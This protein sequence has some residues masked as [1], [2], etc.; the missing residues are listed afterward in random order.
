MINCLPI[1]RGINVNRGQVSCL[2]LIIVIAITTLAVPSTYAITVN[3]TNFSTALDTN[4]KSWLDGSTFKYQV[5]PIVSTAS[6]GNGILANTVFELRN[7]YHLN[8]L[9]TAGYTGK[10][11]TIVIVNAY[12]SPTICEDLL[13]FIQWQNANGA[14]L[15]WTKIE[16]IKNHLRI[17]YPMGRPIF[18]A[19]DPNQLAWSTET[20]LDVDMVHGIAPD[21]DIALVIAPNN[22]NRPLDYAV[23]YSIFNHLG[24]TISLSWGEPESEII[25]QN[26]VSQVRISHAIFKLA[27]YEG[28]TVFAGS[29]D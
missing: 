23:F 25:E 3:V 10:G 18:D 21:A 4:Y 28:I 29:G 11:Q 17:Y 16:E 2:T 7:A 12:G 13:M 22:N 1:S 8:P 24:S 15:P 5:N 20:T 6:Y 9:Y 26:Q 19:S 14:N 27:M